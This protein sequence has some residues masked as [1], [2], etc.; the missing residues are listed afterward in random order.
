[1]E[2]YDREQ[3]KDFLES[4]GYTMVGFVGEAKHLYKD[5]KSVFLGKNF[6]TLKIS[7]E[8]YARYQT[9]YEILTDEQLMFYTLDSG[10]RCLKFAE[11]KR[12]IEG[13]E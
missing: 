1:M 5:E 3:F 13:L 9:A 6:M 2:T 10:V 7:R 8:V 12:F 11:F 4:K